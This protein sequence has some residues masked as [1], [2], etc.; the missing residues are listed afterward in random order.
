[1]KAAVNLAE[2]RRV[3]FS[4]IKTRNIFRFPPRNETAPVRRVKSGPAGKLHI[5][6]SLRRHL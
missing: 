1:M 4:L 6:R 5:R 2:R 3:A